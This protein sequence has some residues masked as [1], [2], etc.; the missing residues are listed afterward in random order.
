MKTLRSLQLRMR[1]LWRK[2]LQRDLD[3]ELGYHLEMAIQ[4]KIAAGADPGEARYEALRELGNATV[5]KER[6][7]EMFSFARMETVLQDVRYAL[8]GLAKSPAFTAV[9][10]LSLGLGI[11]A[12]TAIFSVLDTLLL[13][14]LPVNHPEQLVTLTRVDP[15][16]GSAN[17]LSYPMFERF[18][19]LNQIFADVSA[20]WQ[21]ERANVAIGGTGGGVESKPLI[22]DLV[23]GSYFSMLGVNAAAGRVFTADDDRI[24]GG[25]PVAVIS[26]RYWDRRFG[27]NGDVVGRTINISNTVYT[28]V[29]VAAKGFS[30][31]NISEPSD[32]WIPM[33]MQSQAMPDRPGL[34]THPTS[35]W[36]TNIAR[37]QPGVSAKAAQPLA[38]VLFQQM[39]KDRAGPAASPQVLQ[40]LAQQHMELRQAGT[41]FAVQ[42]E[43]FG[44]PLKVLMIIVGLVLL[45]ACANVA[46][47]LLARAAGRQREIAVRLAIGAGR[48]RIAQQLLT[49]S[50]LL[51]SMGGVIG[52]ALALWG[53]NLLLAM[54]GS[55]R[56]PMNLEVPI[57]WRVLGFTAAL[58]LI[59]GILFGLAPATS[60]S[61]VSLTPALSERGAGSAG[62][63][64]RFSLGKLLVISQVALS[65]LLLIGAGLFTRTLTNLKSQDLGFA[66][67]HVWLFWITPPSKSDGAP[68]AKLFDTVQ[69]RISNLPGVVSASPSR[70]GLLSGF[71]G[72]RQVGVEGYTPKSDEDMGA[73][74]SLVAP[75]FFDT[76]G[77]RLL[78][79]RDFT[80]RD[81]EKAPRVAVI[82]ETMARDF[83]A[84]QNPVGRR[85]GMG[86]DEENAIEI[87]GVVQD[88]KYFSLRDKNVRMVY[89]PY[90]QDTAHLIMMCLAVRASGDQ[91][92]FTGRIRDE[93]RGIDPALVIPRIDTVE[94]QVDATLVEERLVAVLSGFFGVLAVMLACLG[95]YGV[96]AYTAARRTNEIGIRMALGATRSEVLTMVLK[97]SLLLVAL[98]IAIGV[99][100]TLA[101]TRLVSSLLF[102][103]RASDPLTIAGGAALM[104]A[105]A[106]LAGFLPA[107][108]A[109]RVDPMIALRYE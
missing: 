62:V 17:N 100:A 63:V 70:N 82:N 92:G 65:L 90:R 81:N 36:M 27:R 33:A 56:A 38:Q 47:L 73:Q 53:T 49:E 9:V 29:G 61:K 59:T 99:P 104:I 19:E 84:G 85:F 30:G 35:M 58:C 2:R 75:K 16:R 8:R 45:I 76:I 51:A 93:I 20:L 83:F 22:V 64:G 41:G 42:R 96:M 39:M 28:I 103:I 13:R 108:R 54:A 101:A 48:S 55:G 11:G 37:L 34:L 74:W 32:V 91:P 95:L 86:G 46:N 89:L 40:R 10:V 21:I 79:G 105:V 18:R 14:P 23:S 3:D 43:I 4:D 97:E 24:P 12:N 67:E 68:L 78:L 106:A 60:A 80:D 26:Y 50:L 69:Q 15:A 57:D 52:L 31:E 5:Y 102:G 87:V 107:R 6:S 44:Q 25:H 72:I 94:Q 109:A 77:M 1:A 71:V 66:R 88:S 98:G 7:H